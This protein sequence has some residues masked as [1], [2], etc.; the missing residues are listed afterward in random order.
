MFN[1]S[2][3]I[4]SDSPIKKDLLKLFNKTDE[5]TIFDIGGCEGEE[6]IRYQRIFPM[7]RIFVFE[8]LPSN[9]NKIIENFEKYQVRQAELVKAAA[10]DESGFSIFHVSSGQPENKDDS[11]DWDF[12]NKSSSLLAPGKDLDIVPW[13]QFNESITV[14]TITLENFIKEKKIETVDF[15]HMDVQGAELKV[16]K[17]ANRNLDKIKS[18]WLEVAD[19]ELYQGQ[20]NRTEIEEFMKANK[21]YLFKSSLEG[22]FGDQLYLNKRYFKT[23]SLLNK[24]IVINR[25]NKTRIC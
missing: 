6:T 7:S 8:P 14:K 22:Q 2:E 13:I 11:L 12:G 9:Q 4:L 5:L 18:V 19:V 25:K 3:Y 17:G 1:R 21:F 20:P 10:S 16:L 15:I 24:K 23:V